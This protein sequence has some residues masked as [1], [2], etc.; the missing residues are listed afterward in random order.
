MISARF[1]PRQEWENTANQL[2]I[3]VGHDSIEASLTQLKHCLFVSASLQRR[4]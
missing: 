4:R 2:P 3:I 1:G